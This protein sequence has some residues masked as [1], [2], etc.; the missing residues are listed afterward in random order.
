[1]IANQRNLLKSFIIFFEL[2]IMLS[3]SR[4]ILHINCDKR[5]D[6]GILMGMFLFLWS[7]YTK[8]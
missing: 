8:W 1:M 2:E 6:N 4:K 5:D 3:S 7:I